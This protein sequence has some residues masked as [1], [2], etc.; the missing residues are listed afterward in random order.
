ML[1]VLAPPSS[2]I[3]IFDTRKLCQ[4]FISKSVFRSVI[5]HG[6]KQNFP[7]PLFHFFAQSNNLIR[8]FSLLPNEQS[9]DRQS[10]WHQS[11]YH[12]LTAKFLCQIIN[13]LGFTAEN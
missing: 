7:P 11:H 2:D 1:Y 8:Y 5:I 9:I 6:S 3:G 10:A 12:T 4:R 13:Q